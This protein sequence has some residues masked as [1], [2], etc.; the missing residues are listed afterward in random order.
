PNASNRK[1]RP[2]LPPAFAVGLPL[3]KTYEISGLI[4]KVS[5]QSQSVDFSDGKVEG[6]SKRLGSSIFVTAC[7]IIT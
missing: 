5:K 6:K 7:I 4:G 3:A 2:E 1:F